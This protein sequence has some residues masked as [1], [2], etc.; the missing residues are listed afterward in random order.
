MQLGTKPIS[1]IVTQAL[2][3]F[4]KYC[5]V[6]C[7][8]GIEYDLECSSGAARHD[9]AQIFAQSLKRCMILDKLINITIS[10]SSFVKWD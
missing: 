5:F 4:V 8:C 2:L 10:V 3:V 1:L 6:T 7:S 9:R